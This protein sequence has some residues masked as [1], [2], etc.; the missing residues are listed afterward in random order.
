MG[1]GEKEKDV[2]MQVESGLE[3]KFARFDD[4][5][6][7]VTGDSVIEGYASYFGDRTKAA[8]S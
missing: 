7:S 6:L 2:V 5:A 4:D 3:C 8:I 1:M